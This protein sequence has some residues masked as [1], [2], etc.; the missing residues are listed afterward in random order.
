MPKDLVVPPILVANPSAA[1]VGT[2]GRYACPH[3]AVPTGV[4]PRGA[5]PKT[6]CR[7][8]FGRHAWTAPADIGIGE[9][10]EKCLPGLATR[11]SARRAMLATDLVETIDDPHEFREG[12]GSRSPRR[13]AEA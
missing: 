8:S 9:A 5:V 6:F 2:A 10:C 1:R 13:R 3:L 11:I 7:W 4:Q 12:A